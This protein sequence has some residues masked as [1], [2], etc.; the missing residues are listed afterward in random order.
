MKTIYDP[1]T[2]EFLTIQE[3]I[4][5][6]NQIHGYEFELIPTQ[7]NEVGQDEME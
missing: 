5:E 2:G 7:S 4:E 6:M 1:V 3:F